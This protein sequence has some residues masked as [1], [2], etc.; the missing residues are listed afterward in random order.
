MDIVLLGIGCACGIALAVYGVADIV[1]N[2]KTAIGMCFVALGIIVVLGAF[3]IKQ[4][5]ENKII[6][7]PD[8]TAEVIIATVRPTEYETP[9]VTETVPENTEA[10]NTEAPTQNPTAEV[11]AAPTSAPTAAPTS[12]PTATAVP[13]EGDY[14]EVHYDP[15]T[16]VKPDNWNGSTIYL[17]FD[18]GPSETTTRVLD[19]MAKYNIKVTFFVLDFDGIQQ[20]YIER[21]LNE[22]HSVGL[23]GYKHEYEDIYTSDETFIKNIEQIRDKLREKLNY[24]S[25]IMRF[26]GGTS[27]ATSKKYCSGIMTRL[28]KKMPELGYVYFDWNVC[29]DDALSRKSVDEIVA[30]I[31]KELSPSHKE[32]VVLLHDYGGME[33][34]ADAALEI[35]EWGLKEGYAFDRLTPETTPYQHKPCN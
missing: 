24:N 12:A 15:S 27:N 30:G 4:K 18:D 16:I 9:A 19:N 23:H 34:S 26:P 35:V 8:P 11:T 17:T 7:E 28:S 31:K 6:A 10:G 25:S 22:G 29:P 2:K 32:N 5:R 21:A 1:A 20:K 14:K 33:N 3:L 13:S